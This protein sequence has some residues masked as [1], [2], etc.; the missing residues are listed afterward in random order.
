MPTLPKSL[1]PDKMQGPRG[2]GRRPGCQ[3]SERGA[4]RRV[5]PLPRAQA[6][7]KHGTDQ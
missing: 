2:S 7:L 3:R 4:F 1:H 6:A 5:S